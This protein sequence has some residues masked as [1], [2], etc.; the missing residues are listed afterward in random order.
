MAHSQNHFRGRRRFIG[1]FL[2]FG[3]GVSLLAQGPAAVPPYLSPAEAKKKL[4][5]TLAPDG[6][7][8]PQVKRA[9]RIARAIPAVIAQQPCYCWC[10]RSGHH[11]L[12]SCY[13]DEHA[14]GCDMCMRE[15]FLAET[16]TKSG[17]TPAEIRAAIVRG[18]WKSAQ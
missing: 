15:A 4:P 3:A 2:G 11:S 17:K 7:R 6:F 16:M 1:T 9:Y 8:D 10:S 13:E 5:P 18:E 14:S 12:L